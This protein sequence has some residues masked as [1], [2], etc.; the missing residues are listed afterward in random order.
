M[1]KYIGRVKNKIRRFNYQ[2]RLILSSKAT[3]SDNV[4]LPQVNFIWALGQSGTFLLYDILACS[5]MFAFFGVLPPRKKGFFNYEKL[6]PLSIAPQEGLTHYFKDCGLP[7]ESPDGKWIF[8]DF[9]DKETSGIIDIVKIVARYKNIHLL[10]QRYINGANINASTSILD[11]SVN[12]I[13]MVDLLKH[14]F[15]D[16]KHLFIIRD[17]RYVFRSITMRE[18]YP[19]KYRNE[20]YT[21]YPSGFYSNIYKKKWKNLNLTYEENT[22]LQIN[23]IL[24]TAFDKYIPFND[25][26]IIIRLEHFIDNVSEVISLCMNYLGQHNKSLKYIEPLLNRIDR[27]RARPLMT[28]S[29]PD[30]LNVSQDFYECLQNIAIDLGYDS[31]KV[32]EYQKSSQGLRKL[33]D[34]SFSNSPVDLI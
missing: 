4:D 1:R 27:N 28:L 17:P 18:L 22:I 10:T 34:F 12:Y 2:K 14:L 7:F 32:G 11:K 15:P 5:G 29:A 19:A 20:N 8:N 9:I 16:S 33:S 6:A 13:L 26:I 25:D 30:E 3:Y 23:W 21:G 31:E 24:K